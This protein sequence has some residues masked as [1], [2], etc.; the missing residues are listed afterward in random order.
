MM[1]GETPVSSIAHLDFTP[2]VECV[3]SDHALSLNGCDS[4]SPAE[5]LIEDTHAHHPA[6]VRH[7]IP[8]CQ[9]KQV[10]MRARATVLTKCGACRG[11][12]TLGERFI[13]HGR[14]DA[15]PIDP[16]GTTP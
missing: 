8:I 6:G 16:E 12:L 5:Y 1:A 9:G 4:A 10:W 7:R 2:T 11:T 15:F 3:L 13:Y 14:I